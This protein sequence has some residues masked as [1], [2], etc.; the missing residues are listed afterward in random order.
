MRVAE[1]TRHGRLHLDELHP[2][3]RLVAARAVLLGGSAAAAGTVSHVLGN[4][5]MPALVPYLVLLAA[6]FAVA[7]VLVL[8]RA[9][10]TRILLALVGGQS[11]MHLVLSSLAG[12][13]GSASSE[14][15]WWAH[16]AQH[17]TEQ[18]LGMLVAHTVGALALGLFLAL[19][20][21][22]LFRA[23]TT[24][25]LRQYLGRLLGRRRALALATRP[26]T[27]RPDPAPTSAPVWVPTPSAARPHLARRGPPVLLAG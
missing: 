21:E 12:H 26:T 27:V 1:A 17:L 4:G 22:R 14:G 13:R 7:G 9:S 3:A 2:G 16:Q 11:L 23:L 24:G 25:V 5:I 8:T 18:G 20:E 6:C 19:A 10:R 15:G